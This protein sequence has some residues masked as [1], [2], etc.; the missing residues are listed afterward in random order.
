MHV[1]IWRPFLQ[2]LPLPRQDE[3]GLTSP[4]K[5]TKKIH[6]AGPTSQHSSFR[7]EAGLGQCLDDLVLTC[8]R[9]RK[10]NF[11]DERRSP[12]PYL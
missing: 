7:N 11:L 10:Q 2:L 12:K 8:H 9:L 5:E 4:L 1:A 3:L 6:A